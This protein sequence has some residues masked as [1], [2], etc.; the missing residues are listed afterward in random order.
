MESNNNQTTQPTVSEYGQYGKLLGEAQTDSPLRAAE[1][2]FGWVIPITPILTREEIRAC[3][4]RYSPGWGSKG[5]L[6]GG[7]EEIK[8]RISDFLKN[9]RTR[10]D[11]KVFTIRIMKDA[12]R[13]QLCADLTISF[14]QRTFARVTVWP[15]EDKFLAFGTAAFG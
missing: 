8:E 1:L 14:V 10:P 15:T 6:E 11:F 4:D 7:F 12:H 5:L 13:R 2:L 9:I 3:Y